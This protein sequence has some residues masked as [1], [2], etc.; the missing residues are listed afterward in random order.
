MA[1]QSSHSS[2]SGKMSEAQQSVEEFWPEVMQEMVKIKHVEPGNQLLPLARIKKI[3]KLDEDVK[4]ISAE[5]PLLFAKAAEI[6][7]Q[8]LTLRAWLHTEENK[9]RTLQRSDI[10]MAI[11]KYDQFDFLIDI[12]PREEI[13]PARRDFETKPS[14]D[15]VQYYLQLA[16]Q[17]QQALQDSGSGSGSSSST[18]N[19][20]QMQT[21]PT[22]TQVKLQQPQVQTLQQTTPQIT[23]IAAPT[24]N[25]ILTNPATG[26]ATIQTA[27]TT[28]IN[29]TQLTQGQPLQLMQQVLT[30][31]G[32]VTH[33]PIPLTQSQLNF[34][35]SQIQ[36]GGAGTA[37]A[38]PTAQPTGQPIIIQAPQLQATPT[39]IQTAPTGLFLNAAQ[40]QQ[41]QQQQQQHH[42]IQQ[43]PIHHQQQQQQQHQQQQQYE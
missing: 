4:M 38:T 21:A 10:A 11:A 5:A 6:F 37:T 28:A 2:T 1:G 25:I 24:Q 34:I 23:A 17:H 19:V 13:K 36:L 3:M 12:V 35:R 41:L 32:E 29:A 9:R 8:E 20:L 30:S 14:T 18:T 39:I 27:G 22:L 33:I 40:L 42:I 31:T 26:Q 16:Q 43:S 7:I 15:D